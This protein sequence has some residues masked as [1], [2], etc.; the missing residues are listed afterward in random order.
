MES[1]KYTILNNNFDEIVYGCENDSE[2]PE[3]N[4]EYL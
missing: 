2:I 4:M 1:Y 3:P